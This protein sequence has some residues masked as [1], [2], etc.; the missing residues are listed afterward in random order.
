M[1][2]ILGKEAPSAAP[3]SQ[4]LA[5]EEQLAYGTPLPAPMPLPQPV[6][7]PSSSNT[8][9]QPEGSVA[10]FYSIAATQPGLAGVDLG[11]TLIKCVVARLAAEL[12]AVRKWVTLSPVPGFR[13]WLLSR[14]RAATAAAGRAAVGAASGL[15]LGA[16]HPAQLLAEL[17]AEGEAWRQRASELQPLML[18]LAAHY[19]LHERRRSR[20]RVWGLY[21]GCT[22]GCAAD[23]CLESCTA[24]PPATS[25]LAGPCQCRS[26]QPC[27]RDPVTRILAFSS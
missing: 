9:G 8:D 27:L 12:P 14:L 25:P 21:A 18:R 26:H 17:E 19:L 24:A 11:H 10:V 4:Q 15:W 5:T 7:A 3:S 1:P 23:V 6:H 16:M 2:E 20:V 22:V 13:A